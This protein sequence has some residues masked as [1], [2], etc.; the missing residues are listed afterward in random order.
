MRND[1]PRCRRSALALS[2]LAAGAMLSTA[3]FA[4]AGST[5]AVPCASLAGLTL[6]NTTITTAQSVENGSFTPPGSTTPITGLPN[7]CRVAGTLTPTS[8][9]LILFEVWL[10]ANWSSRY[11]QVGNGGFGQGIQYGRMANALMR[12]DATGSTDDGNPANTGAAFV[13]GHPEKVIDFGYRAV[14]L[15]AVTAKE[16]VRAYYSQD[17]RWAYFNGCSEGGREALMEAQRFPED[18]DGILAGDPAQDL[19][20]QQAN[21]IWNAQALYEN[22]ASTISPAQAPAI[23]NAALAACDTAGDDV[24]DG[25]VGNPLACHFDPSVLLCEGTPDNNCLTA[26]QVKALRRVYQVRTIRSPAN[27][28]SSASSRVR[29]AIRP[30][31]TSSSVIFPASD[32]TQPSSGITF[33][34]DFVYENPNWDYTTFNFTSDLSYARDK[35]VL[36]QT[37]SSVVDATNPDLRVFRDRGSKLIQY[38]GWTDPWITPSSV[39]YYEDVLAFTDPAKRRDALRQTQSFYRLFMIPGMLHC[40]GGPGPCPLARPPRRRSP[41]PI[42]F[43]WLRIPST[44]SCSQSRPGWSRAGHQQC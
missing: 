33:Y 9:S 32:T 28:S 37:L 26:P 17:T 43:R 8:D 6:P 31:T 41:R 3:A 7:F 1:V 40:H 36:D 21:G 39:P 25:V 38:H 5:G 11:Q 10:P 42:P 16:I 29:R 24:V 35:P 15:T 27:A 23:G 44:T 34:A 12:G 13:I 22:P 18:F 14:H 30:A 20:N 19:V 4:Q 2:G